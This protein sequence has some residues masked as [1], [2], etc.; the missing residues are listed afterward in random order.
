MDVDLVQ[1]PEYMRTSWA[2]V[3]SEARNKAGPATKRFTLVRHQMRP[4]ICNSA[5]FAAFFEILRPKFRM[6]GQGRAINGR[7]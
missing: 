1:C 5:D 6:E 7:V 2:L 3:E 4:V